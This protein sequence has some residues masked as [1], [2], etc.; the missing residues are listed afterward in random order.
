MT[1]LVLLAYSTDVDSAFP[2]IISY[3]IKAK[4]WYQSQLSSHV[5]S[6][7]L[8]HKMALTRTLGI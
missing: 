7:T 2:C 5:G 3:G 4:L 6:D 1:R 8:L